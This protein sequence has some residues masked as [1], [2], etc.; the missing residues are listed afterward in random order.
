MLFNRQPLTFPMNSHDLHHLIDHIFMACSGLTASCQNR[1]RKKV[2]CAMPR[3]A[4]LTT[5]LQKDIFWKA[6]FIVIQW[7]RN[8][9]KLQQTLTLKKNMIHWF[10]MIQWWE[11]KCKLQQTLQSVCVC[12][13]LTTRQ[14]RTFKDLATK[15]F[16]DETRFKGRK[17]KGQ[18]SVLQRHEKHLKFPLVTFL[19]SVENFKTVLSSLR[20]LLAS[21]IQNNKKKLYLKR[22]WKRGGYCQYGVSIIL[23]QEQNWLTTSHPKKQQKTI[24]RMFFS[25]RCSLFI[26]PNGPHLPACP[27]SPSDSLDSR[28]R[29]AQASR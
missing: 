13:T 24:F 11:N 1:R 18:W 10:I 2:Q 17:P 21:L 4:G 20:Y 8:K 22:S 6:W 15:C 27:A 23:N 7:W 19:W 14:W 16:K 29:F 5:I 9:Y 26:A 28:T 3:T 12:A 25:Y